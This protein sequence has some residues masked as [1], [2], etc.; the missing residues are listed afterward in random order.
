[1]VYRCWI[2]AGAVFALCGL[3]LCLAPCLPERE[4]FVA[5]D[6]APFLVTHWHDASA[7]PARFREQVRKVR[8]ANPG[9]RFFLMDND[10]C[11]THLLD[12]EQRRAFD[13][14]VPQAYKSDM[15]RYAFL[16]R[17]RGVYYDIKFEPVPGGKSI[18]EIYE[19]GHPDGSLSR[20]KV[21]GV[22]LNGFMVSKSEEDPLFHRALDTVVAAVSARDYGRDPADITGPRALYRSATDADK[23]R[24]RLMF[25]M[26][27]LDNIWME[28]EDGKPFLECKMQYKGMNT[29][30]NYRDLWKERK[31]FN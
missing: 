18:T 29:A 27:G 25:K 10:Y 21:E 16:A 2:A 11:R 14:L 5:D 4:N 15:C 19:S 30:K 24:V 20:E 31:V 23:D 17:N 28:D 1:M 22:I 6:D 7:V 8:A 3:A 12:E 13:A 26:D 9:F